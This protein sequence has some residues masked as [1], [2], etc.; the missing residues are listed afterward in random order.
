[1]K[2]LW[3]QQPAREWNEAL[4]LGNGRLGAMVY[5]STVNET[6][7][8]NEESLWS[9]KYR[10]RN[11]EDAPKYRD[12]IRS[13]LDKG[14]IKEAEKLTR[15]SMTGRPIVETVY[16]TAGVLDIE[17]GHNDPKNYT[18]ELDLET[19]VATIR[20]EYKGINYKRE[21]FTSAVSNVLVIRFTASQFR[22]I[23]FSSWMY[24][25]GFLDY[26]APVR[27]DDAHATIMAGGN[28]IEFSAMQKVI[29]K[30][31]CV[32]KIGDFLVVDGADEALLLVAITT[33]FRET[34]HLE[35][36]TST[37]EDA[38]GKSYEQ[39]LQE[40]IEDY[41]SY[42]NRMSLHLAG[43]PEK[44]RLPT[45]VRLEAFVSNPKDNG[46]INLYFDF[47][48]YLLISSS[49][50]GTLPANLQGIWNKDLNPAWGSKYTININTEMNYW[51][52]ESCNLSDCHLPL[53]THLERM[54]QHGV[55][56]AKVMYH[57]RGFVAHHNTDIWG[58]TA[59]QDLYMPATYWVMGAAWL[60]THIWRHYEYTGDLAFLKEH[61]YLIHDASLFFVDYLT[62][63][64]KGR[65]MISPTLSPENQYI[66]PS[67]GEAAYLSAGCTMDSQILRDLFNICIDS[68]KLLRQ[69][70][71]F[72]QT[73]TDMLPK[74][75]ETEI[76]A[77]G[78]I[79]EWLD[80][81]QEIEI[82]HRH[83]S[84]LYGLFPSEQISPFKTPELA[85]A[86]RKTLERRLGN[87]GGHTGWSR[88]WIINFWAR[89]L[90]ADQALT[91]INLLL[92]KSTLPNL[93]D[94]HPP[95]QIDGNFGATSGIVEMLLQCVDGEIVLLPA[96]PEQ[97]A[98]GHISHVRAKGNVFVSMRWENGKIRDLQLDT[99][100]PKQV[101]LVYHGKTIHVK[102]QAGSNR[103]NI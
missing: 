43:D 84:H 48:R 8:L 4:P 7:Q 69:D 88:A 32:R 57:A 58:D 50:P 55:E 71:D 83:I 34:S 66:H 59:P 85:R 53:F 97:W 30:G 98:N 25:D 49:R 28:G 72:A 90:D 38:S 78:T 80:E 77:N 39:L 40:H 18:R 51:P 62:Q 27:V 101:D 41:Q 1:M 10:D 76:H 61:Y 86:A 87:G 92:S 94:N 42:F 73:L 96:L 21:V 99:T 65:L 5:G 20:Y 16:Q 81:Y 14:K 2:K 15:Y 12:E 89:L 46:F 52:A 56:T 35:K 102:C 79:K 75:P 31:G 63:D 37:L 24:R 64:A 45:D 13:L 60:C 6:V 17:V 26:L 74:L 23:S 100:K 91:N 9:G 36:T 47:G 33:S 95:F 67:T 70:D 68:A 54:Y 82:G 3:Y 11:N 93:L 29:T 103:I 22:A 44:D 19:A